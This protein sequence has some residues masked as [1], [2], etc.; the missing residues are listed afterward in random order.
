MSADFAGNFLNNSI[1]GID[2]P[3]RVGE[4]RG[5]EG[6]VEDR[7]REED[8]GQ[9]EFNGGK[10]RE[11][12]RERNGTQGRREPELLT[13]FCRLSP[14]F[15]CGKNPRVTSPVQ[16]REPPRALGTYNMCNLDS[17]KLSLP[18]SLKAAD[19]EASGSSC[20]RTSRSLAK[21]RRR[22]VRTQR[23][24]FSEARLHP[25]FFPCIHREILLV[26]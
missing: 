12:E 2:C 19:P 7:L 1:R 3:R 22:R 17:R 15:G 8:S 16:Q 6:G 11:R 4:K 10:R 18:R 23:S 24:V 25:N 21:S 9:G 5:A 14:R 20:N 13:G 26:Y